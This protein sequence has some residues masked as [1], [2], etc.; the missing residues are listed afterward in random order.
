MKKGLKALLSIAMIGLLALNLAGCQSQTN[1][2]NAKKVSQSTENV[3]Q[4]VTI[5][6]S[7]NNGKQIIS[8]KKVSFKTGENLLSVMNKNYKIVDAGNGFIT[9]IDNVSQNQSKNFYLFLS[10]NGK[11]AQVGAKDIIL[12][13][14]EQIN[15]DL[16]EYKS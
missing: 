11:M 15:W 12:K 7:E 5:T 8:T 16:H 14:G 13:K 2:N 1:T 3:S 10:V 4:T 9:K 6:L